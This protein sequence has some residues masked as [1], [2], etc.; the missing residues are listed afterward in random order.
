MNKDYHSHTSI[1]LVCFVQSSQRTVVGGLKM[2]FPLSMKAEVKESL[3]IRCSSG[4]QHQKSIAGRNIL[5]GKEYKTLRR[6][7]KFC[8]GKQES[9][10]ETKGEPRMLLSETSLP[11]NMSLW[12]YQ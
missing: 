4:E 2:F 1:E 12:A 7:G 5:T 8:I 11:N 3:N 6:S 10:G 9:G